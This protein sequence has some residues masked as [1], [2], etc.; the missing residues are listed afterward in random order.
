MSCCNCKGVEIRNNDK[1]LSTF[2]QDCMPD[3]NSW[4]VPVDKVP[5]PFLM[6][7][8]HA[9]ITPDN[10]VYVLSHDRLRAIEVTGG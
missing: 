8:V 1:D 4:L 3:G 2:C 7:R 5:D 9:Y 6:D 10:K